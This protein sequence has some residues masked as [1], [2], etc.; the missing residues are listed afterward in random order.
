[1]LQVLKCK[2]LKLIIDVV[3]LSYRPIVRVFSEIFISVLLALLLCSNPC[4][5]TESTAQRRKQAGDEKF[6]FFF[7][8]IILARGVSAYIKGF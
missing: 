8:V 4:S 7:L 2:I 6:Y 1:M 3:D 5:G